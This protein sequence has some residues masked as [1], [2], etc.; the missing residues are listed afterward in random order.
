VTGTIA[1]L[2]AL[3]LW[4]TFDISFGNQH[5]FY[6]R[7]R[8]N[9]ASQRP[10]KR[11]LPRTPIR[12]LNLLA[13]LQMLPITAVSSKDA[14]DLRQ[15]SRPV[16]ARRDEFAIAQPAARFDLVQNLVHYLVYEAT[17]HPRGEDPPLPGAR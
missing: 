1:T 11:A 9:P 10:K 3:W 7:S 4:R 5:A 17:Q 12:S 14:F 16:G 8:A 15:S 6:V 13:I 2:L